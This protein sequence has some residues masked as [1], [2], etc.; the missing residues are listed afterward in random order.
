[1]SDGSLLKEI[2]D[3]L[4]DPD[5]I[6]LFALANGLVGD[7]EIENRLREL[8][9]EKELEWETHTDDLWQEVLSAM[10]SPAKKPRL[11]IDDDQP[12]TSGQSGGGEGSDSGDPL[13]KPY[14]IWKRDTRTFKKNFARDTTFK[15]KFNEQWR[16]DKLIDIQNKLHNMFDD[17][18]SQARG[19]DADLGRVV[20]GHPSLNNPIVVPLQS[21]EKLNADVV[22]GEI[23][24]VLN[25]NES[26][27]ID[28]NLLV[29]VGSTDIPK[30]GTKLPVTSL[31]G[32][33]NSVERKKSLFH[34]Q[35][36]NNLCMAISIGLCFLKTCKKVDAETWVRLVG[37][38]PG[39]MLDHIIKH[40]V[41]SQTYY[42]N[43]LK[44]AR[45]KMQT[46]LAI[47]LCE[48]AG[49]PTDR[50]LGLNDIEPFE[51]LLDVSINVV[52]SR[53]GNKFVRV[54]E[55]REK[56]R[57]YLYHVD[58]ENEKHWHGIAKIQGFFKAAYFCHTCLK[59]YKNKSKHSCATS[60]EVCLHDHCSDSDVQMGCRSCNR[61]CRSYDCFQRHKKERKVKKQTYPPACDLYY[62]CKKCRVV[63]EHAKR[64][65]DQHKCSEW[66][67]PNCLEYQTDDHQCYQKAFKSQIE[68]RKKKLFS[69]TLRRDKT[70]SF[71]ANKDTIRLA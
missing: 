50:Y 68:K 5:T 32:P 35:N 12:S 38:E 40:R 31:F 64:S 11:S 16:G 61:V 63:L 9:Q 20:L 21:W 36:D 46:E 17:L 53:V 45:K 22:M 6:Q 47:S 42:N 70:T 34:V 62:Q 26:L 8:Q 14:Y 71:I 2:L 56:S 39:T 44:T 27:P 1:M 19:H 51:T 7:A 30:G 57:I 58:S 54:T 25:S 49:V 29:T 33:K 52:S 59:P 66:Q 67:C 3:S 60:C 43:I 10:E 48:R 37:D 55:D 41:V 69:T 13:E 65:P 28:E 15:V 23:T 4:T 24:K 18:L